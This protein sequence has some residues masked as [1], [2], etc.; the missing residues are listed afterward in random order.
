MSGQSFA[1]IDAGTS[2]PPFTLSAGKYVVAARPG[3]T[4]PGQWGGLCS[5]QARQGANFADVGANFQKPGSTT[6]NLATGSYRFTALRSATSIASV[7]P[8][9]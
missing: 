9:T 7:T 6:L 2:T 8:T 1:R 3:Q 4:A 5:L